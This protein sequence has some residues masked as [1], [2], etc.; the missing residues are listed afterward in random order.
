VHR[1]ERLIRRF[2]DLRAVD[3]RDGI[4]EIVSADVAWHDPY[5]SPHGGDLV[6][7]ESVFTSIFD[8]AG[9][10]TGGTSRLTVR[11]VVAGDEYAAAV[12]D[13]SSEIHG[14]RMGGTELAV[15]RIL[16]GRIVEAWFFVEDQERAW[17]F[18][19]DR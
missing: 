2:Y 17:E 4:R 15:Y 9:E 13:W 10:L 11:D 18:F 16:G 7:L 12:I 6:G 3:D 1:N 19:S 14:R 8:E 5:P